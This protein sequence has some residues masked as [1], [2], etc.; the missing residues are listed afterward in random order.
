MRIEQN[1]VAKTSTV[2]A[3]SGAA[4]DVAALKNE[5]NRLQLELMRSRVTPAASTVYT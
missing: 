1:F 4:G 3:T 5:I 2:L